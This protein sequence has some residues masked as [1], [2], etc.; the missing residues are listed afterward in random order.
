VRLAAV[1]AVVL[2]LAAC[3]G[4]K[5][6]SPEAVARAW[7]AALNRN[8]NDAAAALFAPNAKVVQNGTLNLR[9]H[10]AAASWNS[11]LPCGGRI[12]SV[13]QRS[14]D[15]VVAEFDLIERPGHACDGLSRKAAALFRVRGGKIVL[16]QQ[17]NPSE[18]GGQTV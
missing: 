8:D 16:W 6:P 13:E 11:L 1:L 15:E 14:A 5:P 3:G 4:H 12:T 17:V 2:V 10:A 7:S 18:S 9:D